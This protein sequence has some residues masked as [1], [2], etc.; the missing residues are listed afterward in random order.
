MYSENSEMIIR[1]NLFSKPILNNCGIFRLLSVF[2]TTA[3]LKFAISQHYPPAPFA[4][5]I[6]SLMRLE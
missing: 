1:L 5:F 4:R 6:G 3:M 2:Q